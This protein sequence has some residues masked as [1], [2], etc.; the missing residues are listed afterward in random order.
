MLFTPSIIIY[1]KND[2]LQFQQRTGSQKIFKNTSNLALKCNIDF[3]SIKKTSKNDTMD[4]LGDAMITILT[5]TLPTNLDDQ[6]EAISENSRQNLK[7]FYSFM[8]D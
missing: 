8:T 5:T 2:L 6:S 7:N 4:A 3:S 1:K